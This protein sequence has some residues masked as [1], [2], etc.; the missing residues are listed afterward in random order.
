MTEGAIFM[1]LLTALLAIGAAELVFLYLIHRESSRIKASISAIE[2]FT[3]SVSS[4]LQKYFSEFSE[5]TKKV[6]SEDLPKTLEDFY[7]REFALMAT[8][9]LDEST[10]PVSIRLLQEEYK[11]EEA[12]DKSGLE[13]YWGA[14]KSKDLKLLAKI[15]RTLLTGLAVDER[16][17]ELLLEN[18]FFDKA[19]RVLRNYGLKAFVQ[20]KEIVESEA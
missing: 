10:I 19:D 9:Y 7:L 16:L 4:S 12:E 2:D 15:A 3:D 8:L 14:V 20:L 5:S 18:G 17:A 13:W 1:W 6:L 11:E